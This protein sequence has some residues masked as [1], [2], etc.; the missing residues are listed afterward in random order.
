MEVVNNMLIPVI[1]DPS[2]KIGHSTARNRLKADTS[3]TPG[4]FVR[5]IN[6]GQ[7]TNVVTSGCALYLADK[8]IRV[9]EDS[10]ATQDALVSGDNMLVYSLRAG[11]E[12]ITTEF[13]RANITSATAFDA[14]LGVTATGTLTTMA[15]GLDD[16]REVARFK[17]YL[18]HSGSGES[19]RVRFVVSDRNTNY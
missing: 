1:Y 16:T 13:D 17:E 3:I 4:E 10:D 9:P 14:A 11:T 5:F 18:S 15:N 7:A 8:E 19:P 12:F 2:Q 6:D